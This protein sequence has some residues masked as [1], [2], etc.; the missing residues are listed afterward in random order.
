MSQASPR[1]QRDPLLD[2]WRG[3]ALPRGLLAATL[4]GRIPGLPP[5]RGAARRRGAHRR[6]V[7]RAHL[8]GLRSPLPAAQWGRLGPGPVGGA[9]PRC[10]RQG[11]PEPRGARLVPCGF[12][13][14][15]HL[16]GLGLGAGVMDPQGLPLAAPPR[17]PEP[18]G[19]CGAPLR[20]ARP[21]RVP[22]VA[23]SIARRPRPD[24]AP[25]GGHPGGCG[26][27]GASQGPRRRHW[28]PYRYASRSPPWWAVASSLAPS[29][30]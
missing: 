6:V 19:L 16:V 10:L 4:R 11:A 29:A 20:P 2:L 21:D 30:P 9:S 8:R 3:L 18:S 13:L 12:R 1:K 24:A 25:D 26:H 23:G 27:G 5:P 28:A 17:A 14:R 22:D 15:A 7:A